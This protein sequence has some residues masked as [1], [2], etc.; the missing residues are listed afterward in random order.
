M[1]EDNS[2]RLAKVYNPSVMQNIVIYPYLWKH[3]TDGNWFE[4]AVY[5]KEFSK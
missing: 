1:D 5:V 3:F 2:T 4:A